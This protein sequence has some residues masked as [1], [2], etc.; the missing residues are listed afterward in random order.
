MDLNS[1]SIAKIYKE[2]NGLTSPMKFHDYVTSMDD[3]KSVNIFTEKMT[4]KLAEL[5]GPADS[6]TGIKGQILC[7]KFEDTPMEPTTHSAKHFDNEK[8]LTSPRAADLLDK[9][10]L[11][12]KLGLGFLPNNQQYVAAMCKAKERS[13]GEDEGRVVIILVDIDGREGDDDEGE[14]R[15][16][17]VG[18]TST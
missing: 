4:N 2:T 6:T 18:H 7:G 5:E 11:D 3:S 14:R 8:L 12:T 10:G 16:D 15:G 1:E 17:G 9:A 13:R